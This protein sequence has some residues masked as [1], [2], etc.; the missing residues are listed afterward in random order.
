MIIIIGILLGVLQCLLKRILSSNVTERGP[1]SCLNKS[2]KIYTGMTGKYTR[3]HACN[4]GIWD[5]RQLGGA[6]CVLDSIDQ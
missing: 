2:Y 1:I 4:N 3:D 5:E 6:E